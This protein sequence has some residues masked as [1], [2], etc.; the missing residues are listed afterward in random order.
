MAERLVSLISGGGTTMEQM[1]L[2]SQDDK[3]AGIKFAGVIASNR[4]AGGI[5]KARKLDVPVVIV[6]PKKYRNG[7]GTLDQNGYANAL[8]WAADRFGATVFTQNGHLPATPDKFI[9]HVKKRGQGGFNQHPGSLP[10]FG[11]IEIFRD[12]EIGVDRDIRVGMYGRRVHQASLVAKRLFPNAGKWTEAVTHR[13]EEGVDTGRIVGS[14]RVDI[15]K[16]DTVA[17]LQARVLPVEHALQ[18]ELMHQIGSGTVTELPPGETLFLPEQQETL[19]MI[20]LNAA[21]AYPEG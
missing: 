12:E 13:V 3:I 6:D 2:A 8:I 20:K 18:I 9:E 14:K 21:L 15:L 16:S 19:K 17:D 7:D 1:I 5:E 4:E 10:D 11:G